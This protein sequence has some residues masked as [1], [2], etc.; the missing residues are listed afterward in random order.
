[1][2]FVLYSN[3]WRLSQLIFGS[4]LIFYLSFRIVNFVIQNDTSPRNWVEFCQKTIGAIGYLASQKA[5]MCLLCEIFFFVY[6]STPPSTKFCFSPSHPS[7]R[8][9]P[10]PRYVFMSPLCA[11]L[12]S[13]LCDI[14]YSSVRFSTHPLYFPVIFRCVSTSINHK[15]PS[16]LTNT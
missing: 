16:S 10:F 9:S 5:R 1:M 4:S 15:F 11:S 3:S 2:N 14:P 8:I 7:L 6:F 12:P 13:P